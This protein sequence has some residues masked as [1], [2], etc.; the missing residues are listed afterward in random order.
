MSNYRMK[1]G[2]ITNNIKCQFGL[3]H[4]DGLIKMIEMDISF[5]YTGVRM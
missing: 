5:A 3:H 4:C 1:C 2:I